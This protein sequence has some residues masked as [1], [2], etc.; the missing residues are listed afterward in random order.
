M[1]G[2]SLAVNLVD[3]NFNTA[4]AWYSILP[5]PFFCSKS[6]SLLILRYAFC[7]A[8]LNVGDLISLGKSDSVPVSVEQRNMD[9]RV[10]QPRPVPSCQLSVSVSFIQRHTSKSANHGPMAEVSKTCAECL[11]AAT[12][13]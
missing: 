11:F 7:M 10:R 5:P 2:P 3:D 8:R 1:M 13:R 6:G 4:N 9:V 12:L